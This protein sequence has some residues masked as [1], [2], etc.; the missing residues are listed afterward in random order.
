MKKIYKN[1]IG[2]KLSFNADMDI[3]AAEVLKIKYKKPSGD[4]N[5]WNA[6][7]EGTEEA[8]YI[9]EDGDLDEIGK[10]EVQLYVELSDWK[11]SGEVTSFH[12]YEEIEL[13]ESS[14]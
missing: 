11:G 3:S 5:S 9:T 14:G 4:I 2:T 6:I 10:W 13:I 12:V 1:D 7:L 8:Y